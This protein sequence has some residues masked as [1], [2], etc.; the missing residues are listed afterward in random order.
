MLRERGAH[1]IDMDVLTHEVEEP[2]RPAWKSI[3]KCFGPEI[4]NKDRTINRAKLGAIV[5]TDKEKLAKLSDIVHPCVFKE[6]RSI[7]RN[8]KKTSPEAI[9]LTDIPLLIEGAYQHLFDVIMLVYI[10]AEEQIRRLM[11]RNG[12]S[13]QDAQARV[14]SQMSIDEKIQYADIVIDNRGAIEE[15][16]RIIDAVWEDLLKRE[17]RRRKKE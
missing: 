13:R 1:L 15:T 8:I 10:S 17:K 9:I 14:D 2:D 11:A 16:R 3:V 4:L 7:I 12:Y 6:R 5:F